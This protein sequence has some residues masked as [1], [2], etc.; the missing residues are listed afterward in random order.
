MSMRLT[1]V[2]PAHNEGSTIYNTLME[3]DAAMEG[4]ASDITSV[5]IFVSEDGSGDA[6]RSEVTRAA[7]SARHCSIEL[8][9]E[10]PRLG[11]SKAVLRGLSESTGEIL[12]FMD[13]DGQYIPTEMW[14]LLSVL[15]PGRIIVGYRN[16]RVDSRSRMIYSYL[17]RCAYRLFGGPKM[18]D[19]SSPLV[20]AFRDDLDFLSGSEPHLK[21]GF[22][23]E[24]NTRRHYKG[25]DVLEVP[26]THRPRPSGDTQVYTLK[27]IPGIVRSH[28]I[29]LKRLRDELRDH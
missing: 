25:I 19:P 11:Y 1:C 26:V 9:S 29:G 7:G 12:C 20:V 5:S 15:A 3:I 10:G 13:A 4:P 2:I 24:F 6:T 18:K 21:Y 28:L 16:P 22:W 8:A 14:Y 23:W 27:R 17:F